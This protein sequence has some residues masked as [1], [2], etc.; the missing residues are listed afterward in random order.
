MKALSA[1]R[2]AVLALIL[3]ISIQLS[4]AQ[5]GG[6]GSGSSSNTG[7]AG[8][9]TPGTPSTPSTPSTQ[10]TF[11]SPEFKKTPQPDQPSIFISGT[12]VMDDGSPVPTQTV[13]EREC[14][15][16]IRLEGNVG[17]SGHFGFQ[18]G[19]MEKQSFYIPDASQGIDPDWSAGDSSAST[20]TPG[21]AP[22]PV[23]SG[24]RGCELRARLAGY[25]STFVRLDEVNAMG[26]HDVGAIVLYPIGRV[27][28][29]LVSATSLLAPKEARKSFERAKNAL[30]KEKYDEAQKLLT[31]ATGIYPS[32]VEAWFLLGL[33]HQQQN[34]LEDARSAY[35]KAI[36][37]D[38]LY[39]KP[40]VW[41]AQVAGI[42]KKWQ[43]SADVSDQALTLD[44]VS[45]PEAY[46]M[47]AIAYYNLNNLHLAEQ[48]AWRAGLI[49]LD[50]RFPRVHLL[51]ANILTRKNDKAGA[52]EELRN[53]LK[54][55]PKADDADAVRARLKEM[56][57][58]P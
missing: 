58:N 10:P 53:Y 22:S 14:S 20:T 15:G 23:F 38:K 51:M 9:N 39:V 8:K 16:K 57:S 47:S 27:R 46:L 31:E 18:V 44:S 24:L 56:E 35:G 5:Q 30:R 37:I 54:F 7:S 48:R 1:L 25:Q 12:V 2:I 55:A 26:H 36:A 42:E 13:I 33:L 49:D 4:P 43:E 34:R 28:G 40:Y 45:F 52:M 6:Q 3:A 17:V 32:Y 11:P 29:N 21:F 50:H 19:G 41:L